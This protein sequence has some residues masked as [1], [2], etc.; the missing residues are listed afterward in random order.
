MPGYPTRLVFIT[1][2]ALLANAQDIPITGVE[3][4]ALRAFDDAMLA[5]MQRQ[6]SVGA[7]LAVVRNGRLVLARGYGW[8]DKAANRPIEPEGLIRIASVS[9][10]LTYIALD[11]LIA[12]QK[13]S[14]DQ[15]V[16]NSLLPGVIPAAPADPRMAQILVGHLASHTAGLTGD[17]RC[18]N[19]GAIRVADAADPPSSHDI[20]R[21]FAASMR[22]TAA[23]RAPYEYNNPGF[24][25]LGRA[26]EAA[27]GE[28]LEALVRRLV[29]EPV[30]LKRPRFG[31]TRL[32]DL[33]TGETTY[34]DV[35]RERSV[36]SI[37]PGETAPATITHGGCPMESM[38]ALGGWTASP[39][40]LAALYAKTPGAVVVPAE[41]SFV[42]NR[43]DRD[44]GFYGLHVEGNGTVIRRFSDGNAFALTFNSSNMTVPNASPNR[45]FDQAITRIFNEIADW[46]ETDLLPAYLE[47]WAAALPVTASP[48]GYAWTAGEGEASSDLLTLQL[49]GPEGLPFSINSSALWLRFSTRTGVLPAQVEVRAEPNGILAGTYRSQIFVEHAG[50]FSDPLVIPVQ[51]N[52]EARATRPKTLRV[53]PAGIPPASAGQDI[54]L[55][56][57]AEGGT[58]PYRWSILSGTAPEGITLDPETG[59][60]AGKAAAQGLY[61]WTVQATDAK[62]LTADRGLSVAVDVPGLQTA[63]LNALAF[64]SANVTT[65]DP[66]GANAATTFARSAPR[67][68]AHLRFTGGLTLGDQA[69]FEWIAPNGETRQRNVWTSTATWGANSWGTGCVWQTLTPSQQAAVPGGEWTVRVTWNRH[70][71]AERKF[72]L[73]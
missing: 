23:P 69:I 32:A 41:S 35:G 73:E 48:A 70:P 62:G 12:E 59:R 25:M 14:L 26:M 57:T 49:E 7:V 54:S 50:Q 51:L 16:F 18:D 66:L 17:P 45:D 65:C 5:A 38:E 29:F 1:L 71:L 61:Q 44:Y 30:G 68:I 31:R 64:T 6:Q 42:L 3:Q 4:P 63:R 37:F 13:I 52:I 22:L 36:Q 34:P 43:V 72:R 15:N 39:I 21:F 58:P 9:K 2:S 19:A 33:S 67:I 24:L 8:A 20:L 47:S 10:A 53:K 27:A 60:L 11:G 55:S 28:S 46:P 56:L 40:D